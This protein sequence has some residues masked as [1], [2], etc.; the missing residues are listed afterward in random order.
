MVSQT[1]F[2]RRNQLSYLALYH[3][4]QGNEERSEQLR[5]LVRCLEQESSKDR[6]PQPVTV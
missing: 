2:E 6:A 4:I 5:N 3:A 1:S